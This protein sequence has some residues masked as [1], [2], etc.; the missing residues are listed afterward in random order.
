[1]PHLRYTHSN[2]TVLIHVCSYIFNQ[3]I[4]HAGRL[5]T[6]IAFPKYNEKNLK[7][8]NSLCIQEE[9]KPNNSQNKI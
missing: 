3:I 2:P 9:T 8:L 1:M 7:T 5:F 4:K 6:M